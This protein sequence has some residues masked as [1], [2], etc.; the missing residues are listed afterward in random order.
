MDKIFYNTEIYN[1]FQDYAL[2][3]FIINE[4]EEVNF[5]LIYSSVYDKI[6]SLISDYINR[7]MI[8]NN[9]DAS[10]YTKEDALVDIGFMIKD[11]LGFYPE[12][13]EEQS[14]QNAILN[15]DQMDKWLNIEIKDRIKV[16]PFPQ[17][18]PTMGIPNEDVMVVDSVLYKEAEEATNNMTLEQYLEQLSLIEL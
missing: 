1:S 18:A 6:E 2:G 12:I 10:K 13:L 11:F 3:G 7:G 16:Y 5:N 15:S 14:L 9:F 17:S 4:G 8:A